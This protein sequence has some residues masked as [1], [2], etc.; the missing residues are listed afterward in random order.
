MKSITSP[1]RELLR[2]FQNRF[3]ESDAAS[4]GS[5]FGTNIYQVLGILV[6]PGL[7]ISL[8]AAPLFEHFAVMKPG[9]AL[10]WVLRTFRLFFPAGFPQR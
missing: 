1:F 5:S 4:P 6:T 8:F 10:D 7:F 9:P 2:L 3:F